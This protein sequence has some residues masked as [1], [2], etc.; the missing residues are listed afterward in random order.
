MTPIV[1]T[2]RRVSPGTSLLIGDALYFK[3]VPCPGGQS[4]V[5]YDLC[6]HELSVIHLPGDFGH[7]LTKGNDG[8]LGLATLSH[9]CIYTWSSW[10][11]DSSG[12][13][14]SFKYRALKL[15]DTRSRKVMITTQ[16]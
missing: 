1:K 9:N 12:D 7:V 11:V 16:H 10:Q 8:G 6:K 3:T 4:I 13:G 2:R 5:K 15:D 14:G